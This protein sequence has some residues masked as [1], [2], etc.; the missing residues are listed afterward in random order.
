MMKIISINL[1]NAGSTGGIARNIKKYAR[2]NGIEVYTAYPD[3]ASTL[4]LEDHDIL[5][6]RDFFRKISRKLAVLTGLNG[7]FAPFATLSLIRKIKKIQPDIL[8]LHNLHHSY[9]NLPM[10]F[11]YIR[12]SGV[13]VIW[14][15]HDCWAFTGQCPYFTMENCDKWKTGCHDCPQIHI[16][17]EAAVDQTRL[18]WKLKR[19]WFTGI[20][21][22]RFVTPSQWLADLVKQSYLRDYDV[23]VIHN[24]ID[25]A[26]FK[27]SVNDFKAVHNCTDKH[28]VLGIAFGW[29]ARKGYDVFLKLADDLPEEYQIVLVGEVGALPRNNKIIYI[30][31]TNDQAEMVQLYS[32]ADILANP[33]REENFPTVNIEA[34]ACGTPVLTFRTGGSPEIPDE[35]CGAVVDC[36]DY[37]GFKAE[38][39]RICTEKPFAQAACLARAGELTVEKML[40]NYIRVYQSILNES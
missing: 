20:D 12:R 1:G 10:L 8:H 22:L 24:G 34:L 27:P 35:T 33:T 37:E 19:K 4:P 40:D 9:I 36:D 32:C 17:P 14:T 28:I 5:I 6:G 16:Y 26:V 3:S 2:N 15:L 11:R 30:N 39:I 13:K 38:I 18:M 31:R 7:C 21:N 29:G 25:L 23:Q